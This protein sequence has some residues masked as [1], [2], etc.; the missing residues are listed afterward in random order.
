MEAE[1]DSRGGDASVNSC[2]TPETYPCTYNCAYEYTLTAVANEED[3]YRFDQWCGDI[4]STEATIT[5]SVYDGPRSVTAV[6]AVDP[7][8]MV[9]ELSSDTTLSD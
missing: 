9:S 6:F 2:L 4:S 5:L 8:R 3:G 7:D 1:G